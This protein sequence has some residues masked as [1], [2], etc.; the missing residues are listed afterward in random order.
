MTKS[1]RLLRLPREIRDL[2]YDLVFETAAPDWLYPKSVVN[3]PS[4]YHFPYSKNGAFDTKEHYLSHNFPALCCVSH[5]LFFESVLI[6]IKPRTVFTYNAPTMK[7]LCEWLDQF[8]NSEGF[9]A[10]SEY[11]CCG[12]D[13]LDE[14][15]NSL[16]LLFMTRMENLTY[17]QFVFEF[18]AIVNGV[19]A[20]DYDWHEEQ[21]CISDYGL[22]YPNR[23]F[24]TEALRKKSPLEKNDIEQE[25]RRLDE[26][27][28][29][30]IDKLRLAA[31]FDQSK[32]KF[33]QFEFHA[34]DGGNMR[35]N[36]CNALF[37]WFEKQ[38]GQRGMDVS[39]TTGYS[40][41]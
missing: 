3:T 40:E 35:H 37:K 30:F 29:S 20:D 1:S 4:E 15:A 25:K 26:E 8:P 22:S 41:V 2:I 18:P 9:K 38:F 17:I 14:E 11:S 36:L 33:L 19:A 12:W 7:W 21:N 16:Q 28:L 5:Q 23:C 13:V 32:L 24:Y 6:F 10:I 27:L 34:R 31:V 39:V